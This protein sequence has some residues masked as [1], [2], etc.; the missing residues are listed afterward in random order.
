MSI[1]GTALM[2][3]NKLEFNQKLIDYNTYN[4]RNCCLVQIETIKNGLCFVKTNT[5]RT[6]VV[7]NN[8]Y[9]NHY[10]MEFM[11]V[12]I[13]YQRKPYIANR[14]FCFSKKYRYAIEM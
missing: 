1:F 6:Y 12:Q 14:Y 13:D 10:P 9:K 11:R 7:R 4:E 2:I 8:T 3:R 5:G